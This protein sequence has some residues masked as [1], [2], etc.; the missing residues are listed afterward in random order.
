MYRLPMSTRSVSTCLTLWSLTLG[1]VSFVLFLG[2]VNVDP[3]CPKMAQLSLFDDQPNNNGAL[4]VIMSFVVGSYYDVRDFANCDDTPSQ[5]CTSL[6]HEVTPPAFAGASL[7]FYYVASAASLLAALLAVRDIVRARREDDQTSRVFNVAL[8]CWSGW[9]LTL[10][11]T[12]SA[13]A[14]WIVEGIRYELDN[15]YTSSSSCPPA[16]C[17]ADVC[18]VFRNQIQGWFVASCC[19][20][21][22]VCFPYLTGRTYLSSRS[23]VKE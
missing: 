13:K 20:A 16:L 17:E 18:P 1:F 9:C 15:T 2:G 7:A 23:R 5:G 6:V 3:F 10:G 8:M 4:S 14:H 12:V 11:C 21:I 22:L 19:T